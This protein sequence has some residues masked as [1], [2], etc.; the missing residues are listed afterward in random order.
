MAVTDEQT[1]FLG[2]VNGQLTWG[3]LIHTSYF[4]EEACLELL[5]INIRWQ[6]DGLEGLS[7]C[8]PE[9]VEWFKAGLQTRNA[10]T[11]EFTVSFVNK[12][13]FTLA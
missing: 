5:C 6:L 9:L 7:G 12:R 8:D 2:T 1:D 11:N 10:T 13:R 4:E 3:E